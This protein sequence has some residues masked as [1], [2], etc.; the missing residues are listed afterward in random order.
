MIDDP[1]LNIERHTRRNTGEM[2]RTEHVIPEMID[3]I[4]ALFE[5]VT[6]P[7]KEPS[8]PPRPIGEGGKE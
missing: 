1:T 5:D 8:T 2:L 6:I 3:R 4:K 7:P